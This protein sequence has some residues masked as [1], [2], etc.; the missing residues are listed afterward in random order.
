MKTCTQLLLVMVMLFT[1]HVSA[2]NTFPAN[3]G[4]GIGTLTP[5]SSALLEAKSTTQGILIPRMTKAQRDLIASPATSLLIYQ[6]NQTA[7]FYYYSGSSWQPL[8]SK[9]A[10]AT[11]S[12]LTSGVSVNQNLNPDSDNSRDLGLVGSR[13]KNAYFGGTGFF[14]E[15]FFSSAI[16]VGNIGAA[17]NAGTIRFNGT[18]FEGWDGVNWQSFTTTAPE[19]DPQV[20]TIASGFVPRWFNGELTT[21]SIYDDGSKVTV[22][23]FNLGFTSTFEIN[24]PLTANPFAAK[25]SGATALKVYSNSGTSIGGDFTPPSNGLYVIGF[26]GLNTNT[27][28]AQ[29]EIVHDN[30]AVRITGTAP[31]LQFNEDDAASG[32]SSLTGYIRAQSKDILIATNAGNDTGKVILRTDGIN[33]LFIDGNGNV[34]IGTEQV[35]AGYRVS[36][37]GRMMCEELKVQTSTAWPDYVFTEKHSL[38]S[39][40]ALERKIKEQGHLPGIPSAA[41]IEANGFEVGDMQAR[42]LEKIEELTLYVI[43]LNKQVNGLRQENELLKSSIH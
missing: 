34:S 8:I 41:Q 40:D 22:G 3:G 38:L 35:A 37:E 39:L 15:G 14:N 33:R 16:K 23:L 10:N 42:L 20:G 32:A 19:T 26:T 6:T 9:G 29:L 21:S 7:G 27:P 28:D 2:Q 5:E 43:D 36:I 31:Y 12:N 25:V 24:S 4:V 30:E 18:D 17:T 1:T 11:L 13:W